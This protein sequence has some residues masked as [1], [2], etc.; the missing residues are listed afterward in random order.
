MRHGEQDPGGAHRG[1]EEFG[2]WC[3]FLASEHGGYVTAAQN[4]VLDGGACLG[5]Y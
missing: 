1:P 3:A 4:F 2:A 5:T